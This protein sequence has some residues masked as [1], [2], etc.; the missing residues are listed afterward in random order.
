[1][2]EAEHLTLEGTILRRRLDGDF[3]ELAE[4]LIS[5]REQKIKLAVGLSAAG[6]ERKVSSLLSEV[7]LLDEIVLIVA[8]R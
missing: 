8:G 5:L 4:Y 7:R 2:L 6:E 3:K 1:M